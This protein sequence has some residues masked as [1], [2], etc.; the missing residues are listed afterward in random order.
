MSGRGKGGKGLGSHMSGRGKGGKGFGAESKRQRTDM[1]DY[2]W[3]DGEE[4]VL[5][6]FTTDTETA[7]PNCYVVPATRLHKYL[8]LT[9]K[10]YR[11]MKPNA[12][13]IEIPLGDGD[14][15]T[16][17]EFVKQADVDDTREEEGEDGEE[18]EDDEDVDDRDQVLE[19]ISEWAATTLDGWKA[20]PTTSVKLVGFIK[21]NKDD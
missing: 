6:T 8:A 3:T 12:P 1:V 4:A 2:A 5:V 19:D 13:H 21:L 7:F 16:V 9:L 10:G 14:D 11:D 15:D 17:F 18:A 20:T